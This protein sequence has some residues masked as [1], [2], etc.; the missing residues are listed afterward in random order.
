MERAGLAAAQ[1]ILAGFP[2][3]GEAVVVVGSGN[4]G[5][6]GLVVARHLA[7]AGLA[8][9]VLSPGAAPPPRPTRR[10]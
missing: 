6:D 2:E 7:E 3:V 4:N 10:S 9:S 8:V 5:G 1:A